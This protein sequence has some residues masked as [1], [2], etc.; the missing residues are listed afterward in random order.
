MLYHHL[1]PNNSVYSLHFLSAQQLEVI[2]LALL[3]LLIFLQQYSNLSLNQ[4]FYPKNELVSIALL[5]IIS[6]NNK[7]VNIIKFIN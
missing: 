3:R 6:F 7:K 2:P 5:L 1:S 4:G